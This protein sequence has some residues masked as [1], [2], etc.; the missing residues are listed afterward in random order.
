[1]SRANDYLAT[2]LT[3][4][5]YAEYKHHAA[6]DSRDSTARQKWRS[7]QRQSMPVMYSSRA[8]NLAWL[9]RF[10]YV[11]SDGRWTGLTKE[12]P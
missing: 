2:V 6:L 5:Q 10:G 3:P 1:M 8:T 11:D 9:K 12:N 4:E 7:L